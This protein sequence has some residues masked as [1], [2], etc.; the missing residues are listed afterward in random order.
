MSGRRQ[1]RPLRLVVE[2]SGRTIGKRLEAVCWI[3][4]YDMK[5]RQRYAISFVVADIDILRAEADPASL[6][7]MVQARWR[8]TWRKLRDGWRR[9]VLGS[10]WRERKAIIARK[11][12][13]I[14]RWDE[15]DGLL[16]SFP[17]HRDLERRAFI[18]SLERDW[19]PTP[20]PIF[21]PEPEPAITGS[22]RNIL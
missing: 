5:R 10:N 16:Y 12:Y 19:G 1:R 2:W 11:R 22:I 13:A 17:W 4:L 18:A 6:M 20:E 15:I 21:D 8:A 9:V 14:R 3:G 7:L